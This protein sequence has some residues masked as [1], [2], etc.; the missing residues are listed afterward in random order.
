MDKRDENKQLTE[1]WGDT[2]SLKELLYSTIIGVTFTMVFYLVGRKIFTS[3][4]T[5]EASLASGYSLLVGIAG[6]FIAG[7][8][9]AKSFRPKRIIEERADPASL[10]EIIRDF[11]MSVEDEV[12]ALSNLDPS[13]IK[14][15]E[16]VGL[17]SLLSLIPEGSPNYKKEYK[18]LAEGKKVEEV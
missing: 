8:I 6:C 3:M 5:I 17:Y 15:M 7:V 2:V 10:E 1:V 11:G 16:D 4:G 12:A 14:E 18:I 13:V 9:S